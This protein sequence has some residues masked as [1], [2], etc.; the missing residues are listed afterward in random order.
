MKICF[1]NSSAMGTPIEL[2]IGM[3]ALA[4]YLNTT[5]KHESRIIDF[6]FNQKKWKEHLHKRLAE[7]NPDVIGLHCTSLR[8]HFID[9]IISEI[10][11]SFAIPVI[12]GGAQATLDPER[13]MAFYRFDA[14]CLGDGEESVKE[15]LD[16][17]EDGISMSGVKGIWAREGN[18][19]IRNPRRPFF[20]NLDTLPYLDWRLWRDLSKYLIWNGGML[21][22]MGC[23][24]CPQSCTYCSE[25][26][27]RAVTPGEHYRLR[28]PEHIVK[29]ACNFWA[30][31]RPLGLNF[32]SF[33]DPS[34]TH[35][36]EWVLS[37]CVEYEKANLFKK[38][39]FSIFGR[40]DE[41]DE[42]RMKALA[43]VGCINIKLG[44]DT[45][46]E[47][48][49]NTVYEKGTSNDQIKKAVEICKKCGIYSTGY[50]I[51]GHPQEN[52]TSMIKTFRLMISLDCTHNHIFIFRPLPSTRARE[53][54][55]NCK[56][57]ID[58]IKLS[59]MGG[60]YKSSIGKDSFL[61]NIL[62]D[63]IHHSMY[64]WSISKRM[65]KLFKKRK[66]KYITEFVPF[67][68]MGLR[69]GLSLLVIFMSYLDTYPEHIIPKQYRQ[70]NKA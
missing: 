14:I 4:S 57:E 5:K 8:M 24:G 28:R 48:I 59:K 51:I 34:F 10:R 44:I 25:H 9:E 27:L 42:E 64:L 2:H 30:K 22:I 20:S 15:Y 65:L 61:E 62:V 31:Y 17:L 13:T 54:L 67:L 12:G 63:I 35:D 66:L 49:R 16:R 1:I 39:P 47:W 7:E 53:K 70:I 19:I 3:T 40:V 55:L 33:F 37:F 69:E 26:A 41:V 50:F 36:K 18:E 52:I 23:R 21:P 58:D 11:N 56:K 46:D 32:I 68:S 6:S 43:S 45:G 29:E 60:I 38:L